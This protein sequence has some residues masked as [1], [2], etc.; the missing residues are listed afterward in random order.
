M[1]VMTVGHNINKQIL[2]ILKLM[3]C[4]LSFEIIIA[5]HFSSGRGCK[6]TTRVMIGEEFLR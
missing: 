3:R 4:V 1:I 5:K 2:L 6:C